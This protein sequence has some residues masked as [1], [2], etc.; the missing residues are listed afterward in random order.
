MMLEAFARLWRSR[1]DFWGT[2]VPALAILVAAFWIASRFVEPAPPKA[3]VMSGG[4]EG[5]AYEGYAARYRE[6]L[7][8]DGVDLKILPSAGSVDNLKRLMDEGSGVSVG[9]VQGG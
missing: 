4:S 2:L 7:A 5:G 6:L 8:A 1:R 3:V 9:F